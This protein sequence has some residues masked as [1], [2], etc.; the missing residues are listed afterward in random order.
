MR[1]ENPMSKRQHF[2]GNDPPIRASGDFTG[3]DGGAPSEGLEIT[4]ASREQQFG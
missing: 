3:S 4:C 2:L 1:K